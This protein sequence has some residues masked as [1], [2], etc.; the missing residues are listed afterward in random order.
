M[1]TDRLVAVILLPV[2]LAGAAP[3]R[4]QDALSRVGPGTEVRSVEFRV[5]GKEA[6]DEDVLRQKIALTGQGSLVGLRRVFGFIPGVP[7]VGSH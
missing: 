5:V 3:L 4:A 7:K 6:L 2:L 1:R